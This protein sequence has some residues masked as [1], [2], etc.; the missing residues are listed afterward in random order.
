M[1]PTMNKILVLGIMVT[2]ARS[3]KHE[4][5][6]FS[7]FPEMNPKKYESQMKQNIIYGAFGLF[8]L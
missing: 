8:F 7:G 6:E 4:H 1:S 3:Q 2:S 5:A